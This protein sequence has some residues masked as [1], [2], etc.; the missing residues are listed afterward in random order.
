MKATDRPKEVEAMNAEASTEIP[1]SGGSMNSNRTVFM[2]MLLFLLLL[3]TLFEFDINK[4]SVM[5]IYKQL[6]N[7]SS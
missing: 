4:K 6:R 1:S 7:K 2:F 5:F 3:L